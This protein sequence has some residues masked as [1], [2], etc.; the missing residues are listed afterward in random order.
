MNFSFP[1]AFACAWHRIR[2][3]LIISVLA[4]EK[5]HRNGATFLPARSV[6]T[7]QSVEQPVESLGAMHD[8]VRIDAPHHLSGGVEKAPRIA[9]TKVLV[10][11]SSP[12]FQHTGDLAR[13]DCPAIRGLDHEIVSLRIGDTPIPVTSDA[14]ID[15]KE[16][17]PQSSDCP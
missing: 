16:S 9:G 8:C 11:W 6:Q 12:F 3:W 7:D 5:P 10:R 17:L 4:K 2:R 1:T 13:R 15:L 14:F